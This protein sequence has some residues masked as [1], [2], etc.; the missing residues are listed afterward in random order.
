MLTAL[1]LPAG[2]TGADALPTD[3]DAPVC[4]VFMGEAAAS[5]ALARQPGIHREFLADPPSD[6]Q[7]DALLERLAWKRHA[8][9]TI[10]ALDLEAG[11]LQ[12]QLD[13]LQEEF[14]SLGGRL[15][16]ELQAGL[17][18]ITGFARQLQQSA[19]ARLDFTE[20]RHLDLIQ[21]TAA[22][23][24][25][26]TRDLVALAQ[27]RFTRAES[28][29]IDLGTL[30]GECI[31][32]LAPSAAR[33]EWKV[34]DLPTI[35]GD[36]ALLRLAL[37]HLLANAVKFS[38]AKQRPCVE[39]LAVASHAGTTMQVLDNGVGFD[40]SR[41]HRLFLPFERLHPARDYEGSGLGL[42]M[43]RAIVERHGGKVAAQ[44]R[45]TGGASFSIWLPHAADRN[46][47]PASTPVIAAPPPAAPVLRTQRIL[48]V[49]DDALV[50]AI[51][52]EM[53]LRDG[54]EVLTADSAEAGLVLLRDSPSPFD[55]VIS[56]WHLPGLDGT[57]VMRQAKLQD[58]RTTTVLMSGKLG[59][60]GAG[61]SP[62]G[63][64]PAGVDRLLGKPVSRNELRTLLTSAQR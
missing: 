35:A 46:M 4:L 17:K 5:H 59:K 18:H 3:P 14:V 23:G 28:S 45:P 32:Q 61:A 44:V 51:L 63:D 25:C 49:D 33:V 48:L 7:V 2:A 15:S 1:A 47:A 8:A 43:V 21:Q 6:V 55:T 34:G 50:T 11:Q 64:L 39:I 20:S 36:R 37:T 24:H 60:F 40:E 13:A 56:D 29:A 26:A 31:A 12:V 38:A 19:G 52:R 62:A 27:V 42:A 53:L 9:A 57:T 30:V 54:H 10:A 41:A 58:S 16:H 22:R